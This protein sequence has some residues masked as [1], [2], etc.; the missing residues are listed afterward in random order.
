M[1]RPTD[2]WAPPF[3]RSPQLLDPARD[4][5]P[6]RQRSVCTVTV[7]RVVRP[8]QLST[9]RSRW[10]VLLSGPDPAR[11]LRVLPVNPEEDVG[12]PSLSPQFPGATFSSWLSLCKHVFSGSA[13]VT[14]NPGLSWKLM[15]PG[16]HGNAGCFCLSSKAEAAT[17]TRCDLSLRTNRSR[18]Y[19]VCRGCPGLQ[20][21]SC[22]PHVPAPQ[23]TCRYDETSPL[24]ARGGLPSASPW[25][26][27]PEVVDTYC[28]THT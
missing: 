16:C 26:A 4:P 15:L 13:V 7:G 8:L 9:G 24:G 23:V 11:R 25:P 17:R 2:R 5:E 1:P 3:F 10:H 20:T 6:E 12:T 27:I 18:S 28:V 21:T 22:C 19:P 14:G